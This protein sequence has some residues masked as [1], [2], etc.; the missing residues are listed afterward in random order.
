MRRFVCTIYGHGSEC[1]ISLSAFRFLSLP[2]FVPSSSRSISLFVPDMGLNKPN[3]RRPRHP[4]WERLKML[5]LS[6]PAFEESHPDTTKDL[7]RECPRVKEM[8]E[9]EERR[10]PNQFEMLFVKEIKRRFEDSQMVGIFHANNITHYPKLWVKNKHNGECSAFS[11][12]FRFPGLAERPSQRDGTLFLRPRHRQGRTERD[13]MGEPPALL[14]H[15]T[16]GALPG[17]Q[18][19]RPG[20]EDAGIRQEDS[21]P[22]A[23]R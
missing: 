6:R 11:L 20:E 23:S 16:H 4:T 13:Q 1:I 3:T 18:P 9:K 7:W 8:E 17:V 14:G 10:K 2:R 15:G 22:D 5:E 19:Q 21:R 12:E